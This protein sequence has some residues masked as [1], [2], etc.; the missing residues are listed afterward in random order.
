M[1]VRCMMCTGR[2]HC[3]NVGWEM[4]EEG[5][6]QAAEEIEDCPDF[7]LDTDYISEVV[8]TH[9]LIL[10]PELYERAHVQFTLPDKLVV[11][12][13]LTR[14]ILDNTEEVKELLEEVQETLEDLS[15]NTLG[16]KDMLIRVDFAFEQEDNPEVPNFLPDDIDAQ[17]DTSEETAGPWVDDGPGE[18]QDSPDWGDE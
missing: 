12:I 6:F 18:F 4:D 11:R 8:A 14:N 5:M 7:E 3:D 15:N 17:L 9:V 2:G 16:I 13:Y 1:E 10:D